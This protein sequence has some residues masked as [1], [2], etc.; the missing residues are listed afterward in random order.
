MWTEFGIVLMCMSVERVWDHVSLCTCGQSL[1]SCEFVY[2]WTEFDAH[3]EF[4]YVWTEF[5]IV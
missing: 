2:V 1:G 4:V 3:C 5:A